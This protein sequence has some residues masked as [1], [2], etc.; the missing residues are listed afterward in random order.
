VPPFTAGR[1]VPGV[2]Q[3]TGP[4]PISAPPATAAVRSASG[5]PTLTRP[6]SPAGTGPIGVPAPSSLPG[7]V[8]SA[9]RQ[10]AA[11]LAASETE[12][13]EGDVQPPAARPRVG[14]NLL[15]YG[16]FAVFAALV[17]VPML[18]ALARDD[19]LGVVALPCGVVLP[20]V[21]FGLGW[22]TLGA[23]SR[24]PVSRT[25]WLGALVSLI[26]LV[27]VLTFLGWIFAGLMN[28]A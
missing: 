26:A 9:L 21:S 18:I 11:S 3:V 19:Q 1:Q 23:M 4:L 12:L 24:Q 2:P 28:G 20:M 5:V 15:V 22:L 17:Q 13:V 16:A 25:P 8:S 6:L 27:P 7:R 14:R 10:L